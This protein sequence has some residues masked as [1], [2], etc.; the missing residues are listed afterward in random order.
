MSGLPQVIG[1]LCVTVV[2]VAFTGITSVAPTE[3]ALKY[4]RFWRNVEETVIVDPG[5]R[6][7]GPWCTL[8]R[9]PKTIITIEYVGANT[10]DGR[11]SDGLPLNL[12]IAFQYQLRPDRLWHLYH[13][14]EQRV[15]QYEAIFKLIGSHLITEIATNFTAYSFFNEKQTIAEVMRV[16]MNDYFYQNLFSTVQSFQINE[17]DL[18]QE[19]TDRVLQAATEKQNITKMEKFRES[20]LVTFATARLVAYAQ[21]NVTVQQAIG[22]THRIKQD[23][24]AD[25]EIID[26]YV[27]AETTAYT[28]IKDGVG[29]TGDALVDY[30]WYDSLGGG[31]VAASKNNADTQILV[32]V[33]PSTYIN[34]APR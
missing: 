24:L 25:A 11:T 21:A 16:Q 30:M 12:G 4:N 27:E 7:I 22:N 3:M 20:Q 2:I 31:G 23:G 15:G 33:D 17:D 13:K 28:I 32:G 18:P 9:Y 19:F 34:N 1:V 5:L 14:Y 10:L 8:L 26:A 6:F 29:L